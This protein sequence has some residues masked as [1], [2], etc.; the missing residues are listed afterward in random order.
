MIRAILVDDQP[1]VLA[2]LRRILAPR[3]GFEIVTECADG[4][5]VENAVR[6][7][8]PDVVIMDA[9]MKVMGGAE[10]TRRLRADEDAPPILILTTFDD[11]DVLSESLRAGESGFQ[12]KDAP[13]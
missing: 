13:G 9:R 12:L 5:E 6:Q 1:L 8:R 7:F 3:A 4:S 2:G 11:D 10:A